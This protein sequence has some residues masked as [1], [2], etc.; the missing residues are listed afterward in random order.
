MSAADD[1]VEVVGRITRPVE[2]FA[3]DCR[4]SCPVLFEVRE[5]LVGELR[6]RFTREFEEWFGAVRHRGH[7]C[8]VSR[9]GLV[10]WAVP[11]S[12]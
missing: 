2:V 5:F 3:L 4:P 7:S 1:H 11:D 8:P 10:S 6:S 12:N 9:V